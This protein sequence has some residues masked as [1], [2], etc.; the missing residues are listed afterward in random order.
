MSEELETEPWTL[1]HATAG[2]LPGVCEIYNHYVEHSVVTFDLEPWKVEH[3]RAWM[4][5]FQTEGRCQMFVAE[6]E[7]RIVGYAYSGPFRDRPAYDITV[8]TTVYLAPDAVGQG[9]GR[10]LYGTLIPRLRALNLR[11]VIA[12]VTLPNTASV[13]LHESFGFRHVGTMGRVG[14]KHGKLWAV[15]WW[16]LEFPGMPGEEGA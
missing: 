4:S 3:K 7:G 14:L 5:Q 6:R 9:L 12:G 13:A 8:E 15:G 16:Q 1:R 2:D 10:R 11:S